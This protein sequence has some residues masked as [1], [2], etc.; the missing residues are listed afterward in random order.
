[1]KHRQITRDI[2]MVRPCSFYFNAETATND[3]FQKNLGEKRDIVQAK[4]LIEFDGFVDKLR[5]KG[6][7]VHVIEDD[8]AV[9]DTPDSIF[10]NNWFVSLEGDRLVLCPMFAEDRRLERIKFLGALVEA[11]GRD[12]LRIYDYTKHEKDGRFLEGTGAMVLDRA[13]KKAYCCLSERA[14]EGLFLQ[15]CKDFGFKAVPFHGFQT[16]RQQRVAIYHT[17]VMMA[18]GEKYAVVCLDAIDD[19]DE[20]KLVIEE[21]TESGKEILAVSEHE[22]DNFAGNEIEV[23]GADDKRYTVMTHS[24]FS[25]LTDEQ[26][27]EIEKSS[28]I[29]VGDVQTIEAYGGGSVRCMI[30]EIF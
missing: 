7:N 9:F 6:V 29:L 23:L 1:M 14:D 21:L 15:F 18:V 16:Y 30:S 10:P 25:V 13:N 12:H 3:F 28:E 27:A 8:A 2:A 20:R 17:N 22:I 11:M 19:P 26:K 4:A 5:G 24:T